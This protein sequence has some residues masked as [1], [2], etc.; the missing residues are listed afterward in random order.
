M[1][2]V[3]NNKFLLAKIPRF[4]SGGF[5]EI[6]VGVNDASSLLLNRR[7]GWRGPAHTTS[8]FAP[9][10]YRGVFNSSGLAVYKGST[11]EIIV[12]L[13]VRTESKLKV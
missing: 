4:V 3:D 2:E 11:Q 13:K 9:N 8:N 1:C 7:L 5:T 10:K 6:E 12:E